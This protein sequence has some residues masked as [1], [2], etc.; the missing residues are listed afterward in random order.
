MYQSRWNVNYGWRG[1][2]HRWRGW[3]QTRPTSSVFAPK[4][5]LA[6]G[7]P[8]RPWVQSWPRHAPVSA[9][10]ICSL[11]N[12]KKK[13]NWRLGGLFGG[14]RVWGIRTLLPRRHWL[15]RSSGTKEIYVDV[16]DDGVISMVFECSEMT[17]SSEF[18][19]SKNYQAITDTSRVTIVNE[20]GRWASPASDVLNLFD[21]WDQ[22]EVQSGPQ[23]KK[24]NMFISIDLVLLW[25]VVTKASPIAVCL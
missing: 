13:L 11:K 17:E 3:N 14:A 8:Q 10:L 20:R 4:T 2:A 1:S 25:F 15:L 16:D 19:W 9:I 23:S 21:P 7:S 5:S 22:C 6:S 18:I 24:N 12:K